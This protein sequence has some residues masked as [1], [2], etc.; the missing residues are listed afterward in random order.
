MEGLAHRVGGLEK[1]HEEGTVCIDP[2]NHQLMCELRAE[3]IERI[4]SEIPPTEIDGEEKGPLL[5]LGWG[6]TEGA[7][8][9]AVRQARTEGLAVSRVHLT[10]LN[11]L[12]PDLADILKCFDQVLIP[13][14][15]LGQLVTVIRDKYLIDAQGLNRVTGQPIK[16]Q[17]IE[18]A[19]KNIL[20]PH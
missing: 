6:G 8:K 16:V 2:E 17:E 15:N 9:E 10:Y 11:P 14:M 1:K 3:K 20:Q 12:P 7:I 5:V 18:A 13:E 19:I 4:A